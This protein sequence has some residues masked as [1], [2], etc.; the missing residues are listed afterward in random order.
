[1]PDRDSAE[2]A[3]A[4]E[5]LFAIE[6]EIQDI[7]LGLASVSFVP[8]GSGQLIVTDARLIMVSEGGQLGTIEYS[9]VDSIVIGPGSKKV[10]GGYS[11]SYLMVHRLQRDMINLIFR[12]DHDW[13]MRTMTTA[14][15]AHEQYRLKG[16]PTPSRS[17]SG[18]SV[19]TEP[20]EPLA[21]GETIALSPDD[22]REL[23]LLLT[24]LSVYAESRGNTDMV[25]RVE[26]FI[27]KSLRRQ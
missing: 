8:R 6:D 14:Q 24:T 25:H 15:K 10:F 18:V 9:E 17:R 5:R 13:A 23:D 20:S 22:V 19:A 3:T 21:A 1:M 7:V 4:L 12:G 11:E 27:S 26:A 2:L 16:P